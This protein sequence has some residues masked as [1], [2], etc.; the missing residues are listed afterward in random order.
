MTI[1]AARPS[2]ATTPPEDAVV[3]ERGRGAP[4]PGTE[5]PSH[6]R[7]CYGCGVDH[8]CGLHMR[9]FAGE[10]L[11]LTGEF[12]VSPLQ[13]GAPGLAHGGLLGA[14]FDEVMGAANWLLMAPAVT[15]RLEVDFAAPVPVGETLYLRAE[16]V[17]VQGRKVY[18]IASGHLGGPGG[19]LATTA[20]G[21]FL[22]VPLE[23]F[24]S[25]GSP[26]QV[27]QAAQDKAG[28]PSRPW[29]EINP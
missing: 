6:Y 18:T 22:Q 15:A 29:L 2:P 28:N 21:L 11:T 4:E 19:V 1:M 5:I 13:Q 25:N 12:T 26:E 16:V 27:E 8:D 9:L 14:A 20:R 10:G 17:A 24:T 3:P 7:Y 23:H